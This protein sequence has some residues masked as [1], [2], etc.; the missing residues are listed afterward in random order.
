[1]IRRL[2]EFAVDL[3][4]RVNELHSFGRDANDDAAVPFFV[5]VG[6]GQDPVDRAGAGLRVNPLLVED[7]SRVAAGRD[8][9]PGDN[10][11]ALDI[12]ALRNDSVRTGRGA[13]RARRRFRD[14]ERV[15][16]RT[17][18]RD[19]ASS[20]TAFAHSAR[21]SRACLSMKKGADLLRFQRSY[22][23]AAQVIS[24]ADEM[25]QTLLTL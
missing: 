2:D 13:P 22:Q 17:W 12:A 6:M 25:L 21:R 24:T 1:M 9:T 3:A 7:S 5:L 4:D 14:R 19:S 11:V 10:T 16:R 15:T 20:S 18:P 8:G 23:A